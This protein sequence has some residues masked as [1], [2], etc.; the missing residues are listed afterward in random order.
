MYRYRNR[1]ISKGCIVTL[2]VS[3][4]LMVSFGLHSIQITHTHYGDAHTEE[5]EHH[6]GETQL[7][8]YMH[9]ADKKLLVAFVAFFVAPWTLF[10]SYT[11]WQRKLL[12]RLEQYWLSHMRLLK[13]A[14]SISFEYFRIYFRKGVLHT[15]VF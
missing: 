1:T 6:S 14:W 3:V 4:C 10:N 8:E 13:R 9:L 11:S 12:W 2:F 15:K 7:S 5:K